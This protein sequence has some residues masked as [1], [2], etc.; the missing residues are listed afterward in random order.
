[1]SK[2]PVNAVG[3]T[4]GNNMS[5]IERSISDLVTKTML[6]DVK[7]SLGR[8]PKALKPAE[9]LRHPHNHFHCHPAKTSGPGGLA[10]C[11]GR[12]QE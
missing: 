3:P 6:D 8:S 10:Q 5:E 1:M 9:A 4:A 12:S 7:D 11:W 2:V